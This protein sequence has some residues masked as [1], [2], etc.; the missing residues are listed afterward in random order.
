M[1]RGP[2]AADETHHRDVNHTFAGMEKG[3]TAPGGLPDPPPRRTGVGRGL[4]RLLL[5]G[6]AVFMKPR[7]VPSTMFASL[8][9]CRLLVM[10]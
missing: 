1:A 10:P 2:I 3:A 7:L 9:V 4:S 8:A 6:M 5:F